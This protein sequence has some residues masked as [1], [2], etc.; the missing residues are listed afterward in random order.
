MQSVFKEI[1]FIFRET[2]LQTRLVFYMYVP[3]IVYYAHLTCCLKDS[4]GTLTK[5][6][7]SLTVGTPTPPSALGATPASPQRPSTSV[8]WAAHSH[9]YNV[10]MN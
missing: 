1:D 7:W 4:S 6:S 8:R 5:T 3:R 9:G 10:I 2:E